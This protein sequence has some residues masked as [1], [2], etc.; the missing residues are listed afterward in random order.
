MLEI[1]F[2][3]ISHGQSQQEAEQ[4]IKE[5]CDITYNERAI[6]ITQVVVSPFSFLVKTIAC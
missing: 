3:C 5:H 2:V 6:L 1:V 4:G